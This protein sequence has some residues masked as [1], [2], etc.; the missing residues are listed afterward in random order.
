MQA[1]ARKPALP[2]PTTQ[3]LP[4]NG[5]S[6]NKPKFAIKLELI[7]RTDTGLKIGF[8]KIN[9]LLTAYLGH[10]KITVSVESQGTYWDTILD[11]DACPKRL[12]AGYVCG[13]CP[14]ERRPVS[15][16]PKPSG[17]TTSSSHSSNG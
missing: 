8:C 14:A 10:N 6:A 9:R 16:P 7:K 17:A 2:T 1:L 15:H 5:T 13:F 11:L 12:A 4:P 3:S